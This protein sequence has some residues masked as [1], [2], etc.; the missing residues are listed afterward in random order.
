MLVSPSSHSCFDPQSSKASCGGRWKVLSRRE[1]FRY[2]YTIIAFLVWPVLTPLAAALAEIDPRR[3][4]VWALMTGCG[5]LLAL[6]LS[7]KLAG[8]DGNRRERRQAFACL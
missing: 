6:Y 4:R 7:I 3:N 2:L 8:A 1:F 5:I